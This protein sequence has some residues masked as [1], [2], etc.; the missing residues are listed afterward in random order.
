M[1]GL[2]GDEAVTEKMSCSTRRG[3]GWP[4]LA[5]RTP[6]LLLYEDVHWADATLVEL[7]GSV[8]ARVGPEPVMQLCMA[9]PEL[10]DMH[11]E[12]GAGQ[13]AYSA[14]TLDPLAEDASRGCQERSADH[15]ADVV[16]RLVTASGGNPLFPRGALRDRRR[17]GGL[18]GHSTATSVTAIIGA[19][20]DLL[21]R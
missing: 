11:K 21:P 14:V 7:I 2:S 5:R 15:P 13:A 12:W 19:R 8:A 4:A 10:L 16:E 3:A 18:R 1:M 17:A 9:R 20:L 6:T